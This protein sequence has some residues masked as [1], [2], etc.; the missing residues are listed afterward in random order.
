MQ[1][2]VAL[3]STF[4]QDELDNR[5]VIIIEATQHHVNDL[6]EICSKCVEKGLVLQLFQVQGGARQGA[7]AKVENDQVGGSCGT[8]WPNS[9][10]HQEHFEEEPQPEGQL[11]KAAESG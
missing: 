6:P 4:F 2:T 7:V 1:L 9:Q 3:L 10:Y 5:L 11:P 8:E